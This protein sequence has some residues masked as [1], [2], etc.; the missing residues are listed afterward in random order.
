MNFIQVTAQQRNWMVGMVLLVLTAALYWPVSSYPFVIYDDHLYV[1]NNPHITQGLTW[2]SIKWACTAIVAGN[3]HPLTLWSH[4]TDCS[5]YH[6]NA[7]GHHLTNLLL[8]LANVILLWLFIRRL[9]GL[10]WPASLVAA[11]FAWHPLNVESVAWIS[12]RKN[13]LSTC[14]FLL[15]LLAWLQYSAKPRPAR[16]MLA[17]VLFALGLMSKPMLV[18]TP[19]VLL[20]L[21]YWPLQRMFPAQNPAKSAAGMSLLL[22]EKVPFLLLAA[23]DCFMTYFAQTRGGSVASFDGVPLGWRLVNVFVAY[24][25]YLEKAFWP[26]GLCVLYPFPEKPLVVQSMISLALLV[27]GTVACWYWGRKYRWLVV[28]W[29]WFLGTLI[30]VVGIVQTGA[31][32]WADRH[33]YVPLIGIF[34]IVACGLN[35]LWAVRAATRTWVLLGVV[36]FLS[37]C[38]VIAEEQISSWQSSVALFSRVVTVNPNDA[39]SQNLLGK[40]FNGQGEY[41][42]AAEHFAAACRLQPQ[43]NDY[44][45]DLGLAWFDAGDFLKAIG[46]LQAALQQKSDDVVKHNRLGIALMQSGKAHEAE[47]EFNRA[48]ALRPDYAKSY[49]NLGKTFLL[50]GQPQPAITN[51]VTAVRLQPGWPEAMENLAQ[52][53][54]VAGKLSDAVITATQAL[55]IAH[56]NKE[57]DLANKISEEKNDYEHQLLKQPEP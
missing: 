36:V 42:R 44:Q 31:Q 20:L 3:W 12:E 16:Y 28:G 55:Q 2:D 13:V 7:G 25:T 29:L 10:F 50:E 14:F 24:V 51:F 52:A 46:P 38:W 39:L 17:L 18:T 9:T 23:G 32:S 15:T 43:N 21:D 22:L 19:F 30:P 6:L 11:L 48:I 33:A 26:A 34:L 1:Y 37:S 54:A 45:N 41:E 57:S 53:Y 5:L 49:F 40:A 47:N 4:M 27:I 56:A 8:H 35:E